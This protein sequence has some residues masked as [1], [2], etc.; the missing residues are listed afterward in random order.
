MQTV[1]Y[2]LFSSF[3]NEFDNYN[4]NVNDKQSIKEF[5]PAWTYLPF[6]VVNKGPPESPALNLSYI[7]LF[8]N[9]NRGVSRIFFIIAD[10]IFSGRGKLNI[11]IRGIRGQRIFLLAEYLIITKERLVLASAQYSPHL[12]FLIRGRNILVLFTSGAYLKEAYV[13]LIWIIRGI[14]PTVG[15]ASELQ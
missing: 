4:N 9:C 1:L 12:I 11:L 14:C 2:P 10:T 6:T 3:T 13:P 15:H 8:R 7:S 5:S